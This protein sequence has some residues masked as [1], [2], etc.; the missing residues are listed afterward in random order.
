MR[1]FL[2]DHPWQLE[3][4]PALAVVVS[5]SATVC[6]RGMLRQASTNSELLLAGQWSLAG[7]S[8]WLVVSVV[9]AWVVEVRANHRW[10][11][12]ERMKR[13]NWSALVFQSVILAL[14]SL[15]VWLDFATLA[16]PAHSIPI[17]SLAVLGSVTV[18]VVVAGAIL[19]GF[20]EWRRLSQLR[21][22]VG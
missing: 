17:E 5:V 16:F 22:D 2:R 7:A 18:R 12:S 4:V 8:M 20:S 19:T 3:I 13:F 15:A 9:C 1:Q 11:K 6:S 10:V 14:T 21:K